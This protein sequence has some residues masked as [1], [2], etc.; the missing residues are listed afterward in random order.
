M[1][2]PPDTAVVVGGG[3]Q[4]GMN[5]QR[6]LREV[7][8][9]LRNF[10]PHIQ[11][12][13]ATIVESD[14]D[15]GATRPELAHSNPEVPSAAPRGGQ[16][17]RF[18]VDA[19][20]RTPTSSRSRRSTK[21]SGGSGSASGSSSSGSSS[22]SSRSG[23]RRGRSS[24]SNT[25]RPRM[26][27]S[28]SGRLGD[29]SLRGG[30]LLAA[31]T[32]ASREESIK[33]VRSA[34]TAPV[35]PITVRTPIDSKQTP[36]DARSAARKSLGPPR[37]NTP[38]TLGGDRGADQTLTAPATVATL[39]DTTGESPFESGRDML[40]DLRNH[41]AG[42]GAAVGSATP[43]PAQKRV[44][45]TIPLTMLNMEAVEEGNAAPDGIMSPKPR[46]ARKPSLLSASSAQQYQIQR[47]GLATS[48]E[49]GMSA[50]HGF[51]PE[52]D[53]EGLSWTQT[54]EVPLLGGDARA[55]E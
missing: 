28:G 31:S 46:T 49:A 53:F 39:D 22:Q 26:D 15:L 21:M 52:D 38:P 41:L 6:S 5:R 33:R 17:R 35:I 13:E 27:A 10:T 8:L 12:T 19:K 36:G 14:E 42:N 16:G 44:R 34:E 9:D 55:C 11:M 54:I 50:Y 25:A 20:M 4:R 43:A 47:R 2:G 18:S 48:R 1:L 40:D 23:R 3:D 30:D 24:S 29:H 51:I 32:S 7:G 45:A 37:S